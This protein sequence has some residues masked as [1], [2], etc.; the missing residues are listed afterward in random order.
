MQNELI[1][2]HRHFM[3]PAVI[4]LV[5]HIHKKSSSLSR[6][7]EQYFIRFVTYQTPSFCYRNWYIYAK[8]ILRFSWALLLFYHD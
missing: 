2:R 8:S 4:S 1:E 3:P 7:E 5:V 6:L